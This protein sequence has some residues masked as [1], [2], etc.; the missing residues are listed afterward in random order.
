MRR[1][2]ERAWLAACM[3]GGMIAGCA[4]SNSDRIFPPDPLLLSKH[5]VVGKFDV[6]APPQ[7][8][9]TVPPP[10]AVPATALASAEQ[11]PDV[12]HIVPASPVSRQIGP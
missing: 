3:A 12:E 7:V 1:K 5:P 6:P 11:K 9:F 8:V 2:G 10:P 4:H